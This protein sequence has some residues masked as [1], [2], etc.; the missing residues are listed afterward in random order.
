MKSIVAIFVRATDVSIT[1]KGSASYENRPFCFRSFGTIHLNPRSPEM[2][3]C[4]PTVWLT[5]DVPVPNCILQ[6]F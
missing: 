5:I 4:V 6:N 1:E 2:A 3:L